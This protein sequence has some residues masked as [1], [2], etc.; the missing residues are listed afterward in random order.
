MVLNYRY[1]PMKPKFVW[2]KTHKDLQRGAH[3]LKAGMDYTNTSLW[4]T[5]QR[6]KVLRMALLR[7]F[8][9]SNAS[10]SG[11]IKHPCGPIPKLA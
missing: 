11:A 4:D 8:T 5:M 6:C 9:L 2:M 7:L 1:E 10:A 3:V